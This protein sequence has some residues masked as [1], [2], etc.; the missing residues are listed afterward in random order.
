MKKSLFPS[1]AALFL[2]APVAVFAF[3]HLFLVTG[4]YEAWI[5]PVPREIGYVENAT[6][7]FFFAAGIY[8]FALTRLEAARRVAWM[9]AAL[10]LF[11][12]LAVFVCLEEVS[13]GQHFLHYGTPEWFLEHNKNREFN[14]HNLGGDK[15]SYTMRSAGYAVVAAAGIVGP[16][17]ARYTNINILKAGFV[18]YFIPTVWMIIPSLFHLFANLPKNIVKT[19]PG[20]AEI[21]ASSYYFSESG[22][23]EEYML[24][25]WALLYIVSV[26]L[27][28]KAA[29]AAEE[30]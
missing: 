20:G 13:Y 15:P 14:I 25:L 3:P 21:I 19:M 2:W 23:Y 24:G 30:G 8:A 18:P 29:A 5:M 16:L 28:L 11:G 26:H 10:A 4:G 7:L 27:A 17:L 9:R 6:A 12:V 1:N 22:E